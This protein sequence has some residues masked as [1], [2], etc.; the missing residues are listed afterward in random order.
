MKK[1]IRKATVVT[2]LTLSGTI[3]F[4][5]ETLD[6]RVVSVDGNRIVLEADGELPPWVSK[7][8]QVQALGWKT[9]VVEVDGSQVVIMLSKSRASRVEVDSEVVVREIPT[10]QRFGC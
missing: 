4:A 6:A 1:L 9:Q 5:A 8:G 2:A 10:Q 3:A 7:G